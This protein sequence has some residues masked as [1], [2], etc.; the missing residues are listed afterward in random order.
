MEKRRVVGTGVGVI[1][2]LG[3]NRREFWDS[4]RNGR[5][6]I[7]LIQS[8][9]AAQLRFPM[10]AEVRGYDPEDYFTGR[11]AHHMDRF[12]Q[13]AV[14]AAREAIEDSRID[15]NTIDRTRA[16]VITGSCVGGQT[17]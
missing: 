6:G 1:S 11:S 10:V 5:G 16:A 13:F 8:V 12:A 4:L 9:P 2:S 7:G 15:L 14:I 3:R 17:S